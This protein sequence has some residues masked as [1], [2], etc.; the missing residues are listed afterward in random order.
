MIP[1]MDADQELI[2][3][4]QSGYRLEKPDYAPITFGDIMTDCWKKDPNERPTFSQL[5]ERITGLLETTVS[6]YYWNLN[7]F[8]EKLNKEKENAKT[9][10]QF[11]LAKLLNEK[12]KL[13][14]SLSQ[15]IGDPLPHRAERKLSYQKP[16][17][18]PQHPCLKN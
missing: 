16:G 3:Q 13:E 11:G 9:T 1:G 5:E 10:D 12:W 15:P 2:R 4:L 7:V 18:F 6:S 14:K 8:Y 17:Y